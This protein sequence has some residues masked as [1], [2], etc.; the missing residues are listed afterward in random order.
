MAC[1]KPGRS[2]ALLASGAIRSMRTHQR[3]MSSRSTA[4][5]SPYNL[6]NRNAFKVL[7]EAVSVCLPGQIT[8]A[9]FEVGGQYRR[10]M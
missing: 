4:K 10:D 7:M 6:D 1:Q 9:P 8:N 5:P 3:M 2:L